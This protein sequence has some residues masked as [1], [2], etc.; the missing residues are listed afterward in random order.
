MPQLVREGAGY[1]AVSGIAFVLDLLLLSAQIEL[2]AIPY[3][4]AAAVSFLAGTVFVY[5]AS[6]THVFGYRRVDSSTIEF[7]IFLLAGLVGLAVNLA[8]MYAAVDVFGLH[9]LI[10]KFGA[11]ACTVLVNFGLRRW[12]LFTK[13]RHE[14]RVS[15][16]EEWTQ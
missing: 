14:E 11:A 15:G 7:G 6:V 4:A 8:A 9:Y 13:W 2:F 3:L 1:V 12:F 16:A 10:A 5:W